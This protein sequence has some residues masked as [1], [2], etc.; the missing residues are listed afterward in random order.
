MATDGFIEMNSIIVFRW[1]LLSRS[2]NSVVR[3]WLHPRLARNARLLAAYES[4]VVIITLPIV[5]S[6]GILG[7]I[8][9]K[10]ILSLPDATLHFALPQEPIFWIKNDSSK[11]V[12]DA[13]VQ[14]LLYNLSLAGNPEQHLNLEIPSRKFDSIRP[15]RAIGPY[16]LRDVA[17]HGKRTERGHH[18]FGYAQVQCPTCENVHFYWIFIQIGHKG[19]YAEALTDQTAILEKQ[20]AT[21]LSSSSDYLN[22]IIEILKPLDSIAMDEKI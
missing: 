11:L 10:D 1:K 15:G 17:S 4:L 7:F 21:V 6:G 22:K 19:L 13:A 20:L 3:G 5:I 9:L 18:L 2:Y 12:R 8:Q 14:F 16:A